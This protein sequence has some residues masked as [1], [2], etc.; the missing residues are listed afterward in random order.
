MNASRI[1]IGYRALE[2][3]RNYSNNFNLGTW[4]NKT[5]VVMTVD[6][7]HRCGTTACAGGCLALSPEFIELGGSV[8]KST[9]APRYA[10]W[11]ADLALHEFYKTKHGDHH[12]IDLIHNTTNERT[13][14]LA[15]YNV[16]L[17]SKVT[18]KMVQEKFAI[19]YFILK[20]LEK[21]N[22]C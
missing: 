22:E 7:L 11:T 6:E 9:G 2:P 15:F 10:G 18:P 17:I 19:L 14:C 20:W 3:V 13:E 21:N 16:E 4:Q 12:I 8:N 1:K 5:E